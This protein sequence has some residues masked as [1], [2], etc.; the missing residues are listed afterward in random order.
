MKQV[1]VFKESS[2][3]NKLGLSAGQ[4]IEIDTHY[5]MER[6]RATGE[7]AVINAVAEQIFCAVRYSRRKHGFYVAIV[8]NIP[9]LKITAAQRALRTVTLSPRHVAPALH[10]AL[11]YMIDD[12]E[13]GVY[14][15]CPCGRFAD[16]P[17]QDVIE[18]AEEMKGLLR[19]WLEVMPR[20]A[21]HAERLYNAIKW[22]HS[23]ALRS[24]DYE[25]APVAPVA[26]SEADLAVDDIFKGLL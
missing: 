21:R 13:K 4:M 11:D 8:R 25:R 19:P 16:Y 14:G 6:A 18:P 20:N 7:R 12:F 17:W 15:P 22:E 5:M 24:L 1:F 26:P 9:E 10:D 2:V 3:A 23:R